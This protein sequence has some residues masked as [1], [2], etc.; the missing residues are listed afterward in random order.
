MI[1]GV[2]LTPLK[3]IPDE[4]GT[5][6]HMLRR[7]DPH[8][9]EFGEVYFST[10]YPGVVKAWHWHQR[11][12]LNYAVPVGMIKMVI[13]DDREGSPTRGELNELFVGQQNYCLVTVPPMLWNG[14]KCI[15]ESMA[16]VCNCATI[17]HDPGGMKRKDPRTP[18]IPYD[19]ARVDR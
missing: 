12:T 17:V 9:R 5:V 18:D 14:W 2:I 11:M 15:G 19:W 13:Y 3:R 8:F 6:M 7:D 16:M 4:R 10:A 1:D